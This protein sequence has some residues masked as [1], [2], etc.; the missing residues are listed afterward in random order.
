MR[1]SHIT[2]VP[3]GT[4][5]KPSG[6]ALTRVQGRLSRLSGDSLVIYALIALGLVAQGW[7]MFHYPAQT[8]TGD[9]GLYVS[10]AWAVIREAQLTPYTF[11]YDHAPAGWIQ[12]AAWMGATGG[13]HTFGGAVDSGRVLMLLLHLGSV[14]LLYRVTRKL[15]CTIP[16]AAIAGML[17]S[18]SPLAL[19]YQRLVMLDTIMV[20]WLLLS[21]NL[22]LDGWGRLSRVVLSGICYGIAA[23]TSG[24]ALVLL[25]VFAYIALRQR[26]THQGPF[27]IGGWLL[28]SAAVMSWYPLFASL[29]GEFFPTGVAQ[30][31]SV[32]GYENS[33]ASLLDAFWWQVNRPGGGLFNFGNQFWELARTDWFVRDPLL[34]AGGAVAVALNLLRGIG[35]WR[36]RDRNA[37]DRRALVAGLLGLLPLLYLARG[38]AVFNSGILFAIPFLCLNVAVMLASPARRLPAVASRVFAVA[39]PALLVVGYMASGTLLPLYAEQPDVAGRDAVT[40]VKANVPPESVIVTRDDFWTDL[41]DPGFG[42]VAFPAAHSLYK[43]TSDPAIRIGVLRDDW[44]TV[45]YLIITPDLREQ[46]AA[47]GNRIAADALNNAHLVKRWGETVRGTSHLHPQQIIELWKVDKAGAT[48]R[49]LLSEGAASMARRFERGGAWH[50]ADGTVTSEAQSYAMLRA[51]WMG[52]R[53]AFD[54]AWTWTRTN[55]T[56]ANGLFAW[57]WRN[58]TVRDANSATDADTDIALALLMG[59]KRWKDGAMTDAGRQVVARI[60]QHEVVTVNGL[61]YVTAGNWA[62]QTPEIALNPSYFSPAAY[63]IFIEADPD[64]NWRGAIDSSYRVLFE[65]SALALGANRSA[66][67]PPDWVGLKRDTGALVPLVF[68]GSDTTRY[69]F[70]APR[71]Y[72][73]VALDA[74]WSGDGRAA[75]YLNQAGFLK[76]EVNRVLDAD[77]TRKN[78]VS[79]VYAHNGDVAE[80][81]HSMVG[82]AGAVAALLTLD[83]ASANVLHAAQVVGGVYED[84]VGIFWGDPR[85]IY[86]QE[87]GWFSTA[88]YADALP[89][90]W[91]NPPR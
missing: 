13:P 74:R 26:R 69:S 83:P 70:D 37:R 45:D 12:L 39:A 34:F 79:A 7:N 36:L 61:P 42:G 47:S 19:Y 68:A 46:F 11:V 33:S 56:N 58:G 30:F 48:E 5:R 85:D 63:R 16:I 15:G 62:T 29:K 21:L 3:T 84:S 81:G 38:G 10:Q 14:P 2:A 66:G 51:V 64:H 25:P 65:A 4:I 1:D 82:T 72:W 60:W 31:S 53:A 9:E 73:R 76:D 90:L 80:A 67:L 88:L 91:H 27:G 22:L 49:A 20:F 50:A 75:V 8:F 89:D 35:F 59:G 77:G 86:I 54:R 57:Q 6:T 71:T 32:N 18:L 55:L 87:W 44:R 52:D 78:T 23:L 24:I 41:R 43:V 40:W 17:F 28:V